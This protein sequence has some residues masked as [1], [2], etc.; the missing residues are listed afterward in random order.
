MIAIGRGG[1]ESMFMGRRL[2]VSY[3]QGIPKPLDWI[4][5][6]DHLYPLSQLPSLLRAW[7][8]SLHQWLPWPLV[9][10]WVQPMV[11]PREDQRVGKERGRGV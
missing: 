11:S 7:E 4:S 9:Y 1:L 2:Q 3:Q 10:F 6:F 8:A 5:L